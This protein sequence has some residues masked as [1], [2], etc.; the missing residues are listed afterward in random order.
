MHEPEPSDA[1]TLPVARRGAIPDVVAGFAPIYAAGS[2][3][4]PVY[5]ARGNRLE[6][7]APPVVGTLTPGGK[8]E[9]LAGRRYRAA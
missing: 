7:P 8:L 9:L 2:L 4:G 5:D 3:H 1:P 6:R